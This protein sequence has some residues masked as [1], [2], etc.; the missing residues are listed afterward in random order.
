MRLRQLN[1]GSKT[2]ARAGFTLMELLVVMAIMLVLI[3]VATPLYMNY[4]ESS[5]VK[6]AK[7]ECVRLAG[8]LQNYA[9]NNNG[10]YP[11]PGSGFAALMQE[12]TLTSEPIDPWGQQY[13]WELRPN[14]MNPDA[15]PVPVVSAS[16]PKGAYDISNQK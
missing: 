6:V 12:G 2:A 5:K 8:L 1:H 15:A 4:L 9:I 11:D 13:H 3:G 10:N 7:T 14:P 16:G